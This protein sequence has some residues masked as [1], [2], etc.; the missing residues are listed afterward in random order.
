MS[1]K[2]F[3]GKD[4]G[5][6]EMEQ[7]KLNGVDAP[8][9]E[10]EKKKKEKDYGPYDEKELISA[11]IKE[12]RLGN[13]ENAFYWLNV[14]LEG[15]CN[16]W[17]IAK[18]LAI[19]AVEDCFDPQSIILG[20]AIFNGIA[21]KGFDSNALWQ[22]TYWMCK[23]PKFWESEEG[24][25]E[26]EATCWKVM[27]E[28]EKGVR[29]E[30]SSYALDFHTKTGHEL[31]KAGKSV[32]T[33]YS[34]NRWGRQFMCKQFAELGRLDPEVGKKGSYKPKVE[35]VEGGTA[36]KVESENSPGVFYHVD[37]REETCSCPHFKNRG[38]ECKHIR[39]AKSWLP[40]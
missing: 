20:A 33:R 32:D 26:Y 9:E 24:R 7:G 16:Q 11:W 39:S 3:D 13:V 21:G 15:G 27:D 29:R 36:F 35:P 18:R 12:M 14:L 28:Y 30:M 38:V 4:E 31:R 6:E 10:G 19:F 8:E 25:V 40:F 22:G 2:S 23:A 1:N 17:Y 5:M 37:L 34:G